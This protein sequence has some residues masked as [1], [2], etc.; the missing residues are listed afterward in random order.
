MRTRTEPR[1]RR[2]VVAASAV[3]SVVMLACFTVISGGVAHAAP[4]S[5]EL[6]FWNRTNTARAENGL[7]PLEWDEAAAN[8]ARGWSSN[9]AATQTLAHN[10]NL[11]DDINNNV[12]TDWTRIGENVGYGP[13][14]SS[15]QT[16]FMNSP[17]H[18]ANVLGDYNRVGIGVVRDA[19]GT[20]WVTLDFVNGPDL[21]DVVAQSV[22]PPPPP[23]PPRPTPTWFLRNSLTTGVADSQFDLGNPGDVVLACDWNGDGTDTPGIFRSGTWYVTDQLGAGGI[24]TFVFGSPGDVPVCGD[25]NGDG[26]DTPGVFRS[27]LFFLR[28]STTSGFADIVLPFGDPGDLPAVGDW[29]GDGVDTVGVYRSG[30]YFLSDSN[31]SNFASKVFSY[32][33]PGDRPLVGDWNGDGTDTIGIWRNGAL[34]LKNANTSGMADYVFGYGDPGDAPIIG[35]WNGNGTDELGVVR[36]GA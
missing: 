7:G 20:I 17:G 24:R 33:D 2:R 4:G 1:T 18:R 6:D 32:G 5:D 9:M 16:A 25:W 11:V 13:T 28:N 30:T 31:S 35:D 29:N 3:A 26:K 12:T 34:Y 15:L 22:P 27:G 23:P 10:P 21:G 36:G 14:V 19:H 8:V